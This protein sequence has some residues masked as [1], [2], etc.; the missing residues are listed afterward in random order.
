MPRAPG[1]CRPPAAEAA[2]TVDDWIY[3]FS[4]KIHQLV[5]ANPETGLL[6]SVAHGCRWIWPTWHADPA[7]LPAGAVVKIGRP[8]QHRDAGSSKW[9]R[10]RAGPSRSERPYR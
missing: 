2:G 5:C 9:A 10:E 7:A 6:V 3:V 4:D 8:M 1:R